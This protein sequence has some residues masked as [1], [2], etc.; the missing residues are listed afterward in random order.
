MNKIIRSTHE[1]MTQPPEDN[2]TRCY[3]DVDS[4]VIQVNGITHGLVIQGSA[5]TINLTIHEY[6]HHT[7]RKVPL[8]G[9]W[10]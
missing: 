10:D 2:L 6:I 9:V 5:T 1:L 7:Y 8:L 3:T 4:A